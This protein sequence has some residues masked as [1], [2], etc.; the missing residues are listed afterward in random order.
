MLRVSRRSKGHSGFVWEFASLYRIS[1]V[2]LFLVLQAIV[3]VG[4]MGHG[5]QHPGV[6]CSKDGVRLSF[7]ASSILVFPCPLFSL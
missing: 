1:R 4:G 7:L 6:S 5:Y 3:Y 2:G